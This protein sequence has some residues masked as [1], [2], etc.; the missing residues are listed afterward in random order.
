MSEK[1]ILNLFQQKYGRT[2]IFSD[3]YEKLPSRLG[4]AA[5][6][7][8]YFSCKEQG[9]KDV[10]AWLTRR[11]MYRDIERDMRPGS[12]TYNTDSTID[13]LAAQIIEE[14]PL[15]GDA[16]LSDEIQSRL[17]DR[18]QQ[19][20]DEI[21]EYG[22]KEL[23][24]AERDVLTLAIVQMLKRRSIQDSDKDEGQ[25][26]T[27][28]F[29]QFGFKSD[30]E[31]EK[32]RQRL[33][34]AMRSV[35][36][37]ALLQHDRFFSEEEHTQKYYNTLNLHAMVPVKSMESLFEILLS[38]YIHD[39]EFNYTPHDPAFSAL[40]KCIAYRWDRDIELQEDFT[41]RSN[42]M[43]SG[44]RTLFTAR[45][46]FMRDFC[47]R[48]VRLIDALVRNNDYLLEDRKTLDMLVR[49]WYAR[50]DV[51]VRED[52][53]KSKK[54][55]GTVGRSVTSVETLRI[56]YILEN[57]RVC[58]MIPS[59][60]LEEKADNYPELKIYQKG[61]C[62]ASQVMEVFGRY[63]WTTH[64]IKIALEDIDIDFNASMDIA[65]QIEYNQ[66]M[67]YNSE[68]RLH[69]RYMLFDNNGQEAAAQNSLRGTY[70]IF[71][72]EAASVEAE[73]AN[74]RWLDHAGQLMRL[75]LDEESGVCV[76]GEELYVPKDRKDSIR[77]YPSVSRI[78]KL[79]GSFEGNDF[80][81]YPEAFSLNVRLP[82]EKNSLSYRIDLDGEVE[83][84]VRCCPAGKHSFDIKMPDAPSK[85]HTIRIID[86]ETGRIACAM[87]Y[88]V[89]PKAK[90]RTNRKVIYSDGTPI[91]VFV[92]YDGCSIS[93]SMIPEKESNVV[94]VTA[95]HLDFDLKVELPLI[96]GDMAG[97]NVFDLDAITWRGKIADTSFVKLY[98]PEE[99]GCRLFFGR[100]PVPQN[101]IDGSFEIGNAIRV[102][103]PCSKEEQ[104]IL[105]VRTPQGDQ[106]V[107]ILTKIVFEECFT[108]SPVFADGD[109]LM[110]TP[111]NKYIG[112]EKDEFFLNITVPSQDE[113]YTYA[114]G[115]KDAVV[116]K[117]IFKD[118]PYGVFPYQVMKKSKGLFFSNKEKL[119]YEGVLT[120]GEQEQWA[121]DGKALYLKRARC[122][123]MNTDRNI[124]LDM[125]DSAGCLV[126]FRYIGYSVPS[127]E[128]IAYPEY[129]A[130][131]YFYDQR[132]ERWLPF[133]DRD[134]DG[135]ERINPVHIWII[136]PK[137]LML[138]TVDGE[139]VILD[140]NYN[141]IINREL[142]LP[143]EIERTRLILPDYF[144]YS[145]G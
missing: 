59:I 139:A 85:M 101:S 103:A 132:G 80:S 22:D 91:S 134:R 107:R 113:P 96:Y 33:Y 37:G 45:P 97:Q 100:M 72:D 121:L 144:E 51:Y 124:N 7:E 140:R 3:E 24:A 49:D 55:S 61:I 16:V 15:I 115:T 128:E 120:L 9:D 82:D 34:V 52:I 130:T 5:Y 43:A 48:I 63:S 29:S 62:V 127:G 94:T 64:P 79:M 102:H 31:K 89:L 19:V 125:P 17:L 18:A 20:F 12:S 77:I 138:E 114:L 122:W 50:K 25:I 92:T 136:S 118:F 44:L 137:L 36:R 109:V 105:S 73:E 11:D 126:D 56:R 53:Q 141:S 60:R 78:E 93:A 71:A 75:Y 88:A 135:Y 116:S 83:P 28:I 66:S 76:N 65:V 8:F 23:T 87:R 123:D 108:D 4:R 98:C 58:L 131:L 86:F 54:S 38:F 143:R 81:I 26:W 39:L 1:D 40:V 129:E 104:L 95:D 14:Y 90:V 21:L 111:E 99:W 68:N 133:N 32:Y 10:R 46:C 74:I 119:L 57:E 2:Y 47:E 42:A 69:R 35:I 27:Y 145:E 41:I 84:M 142:F 67:L 110:W 117:L 13:D 6:M 30:T 106:D 70:Y 112:G